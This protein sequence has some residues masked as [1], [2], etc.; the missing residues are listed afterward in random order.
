MPVN[1]LQKRRGGPRVDVLAW[2]ELHLPREKAWHVQAAWKGL[3]FRAQ[4]C[5]EV[6]G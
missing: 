5:L 2:S 1:G 3:G 6:H 4:G